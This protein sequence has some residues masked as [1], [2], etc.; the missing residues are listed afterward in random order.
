V[1]APGAALDETGLTTHLARALPHYMVP[2]YIEVL[3]D[4][5]RTPTNKIQRQI[6]R[7][8]GAGPGVW[9][10]VT[11]GVSIRSLLEEA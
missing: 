8:A 11:A 9:D 10:R 4:L 1:P 3:A 2:R 7:A 5:P 6:L